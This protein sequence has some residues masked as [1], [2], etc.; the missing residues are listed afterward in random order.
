[1]QAEFY[2]VKARAKVST[3]VV[4]KVTYGEGGRKRYAFRGQTSDGRKLT[5]FVN[6]ATWKAADVPEGK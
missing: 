3:D 1:M 6:E 2:D 4:E 5:K